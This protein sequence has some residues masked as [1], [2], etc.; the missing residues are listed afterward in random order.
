MLDCYLSN[1]IVVYS[2]VVYHSKVATEHL[3][4]IEEVLQL[5]NQ[6]D[7]FFLE[8]LLLLLDVLMS[9]YWLMNVVEDDVLLVKIS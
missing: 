2:F 5:L 4:N 9:V 3:Y 1:V 8:L 6:T 7:V